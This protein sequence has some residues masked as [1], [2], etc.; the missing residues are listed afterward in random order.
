MKRLLLFLAVLSVPAANAFAQ[1][2]VGREPGHQRSRGKPTEQVMRRGASVD[3][4]VRNLP[5]PPRRPRFRPARHDPKGAPIL[6]PGGPVP[7]EPIPPARRRARSGGR[8]AGRRRVGH[9][10]SM[11]PSRSSPHATITPMRI[12]A[13]SLS[14]RTIETGGPPN[15]Q[16][17]WAHRGP[18]AAAGARWD[19]I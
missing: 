3:I 14:I 7:V 9:S 4:D 16:K 12:S 11:T 15:P 2:Q 6:L 5:E 10:S 8:R 13:S 17:I 18:G 19:A 1:A